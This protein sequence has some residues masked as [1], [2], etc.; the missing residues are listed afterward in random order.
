MGKYSS[1]YFE[2]YTLKG[3]FFIPVKSIS[4][5]NFTF[6]FYFDLGKGEEEEK[7]ERFLTALIF[8]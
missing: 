4:S 8:N 5:F 6:W 7:T 1:C 3:L 2:N